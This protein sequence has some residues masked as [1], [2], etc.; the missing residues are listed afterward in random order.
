M[1]DQKE[2]PFRPGMSYA[3]FNVIRRVQN[4]PDMPVQWTAPI[5]LT[6]TCDAYAFASA[7]VALTE[8]EGR[9]P[10]RGP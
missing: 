9:D 5:V 10:P 7:T 3:R 6:N 8:V 4:S 1:Y 2:I